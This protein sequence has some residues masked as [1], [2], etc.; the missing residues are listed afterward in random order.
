MGA[1]TLGGVMRGMGFSSMRG[2]HA[3]S[4]LVHMQVVGCGRTMCKSVWWGD[5]GGGVGCLPVMGE[6]PLCRLSACGAGRWGAKSPDRRRGRVR[7]AGCRR[8]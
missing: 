6:A 2:R 1:Q 8:E 7:A 4:G 5:L 3:Y